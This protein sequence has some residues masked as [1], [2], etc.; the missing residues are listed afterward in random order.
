MVLD[1]RC[2]AI[3]QKSLRSNM[4]DRGS[5]TIPCSIGGLE[6][7]KTLANFGASINVMP[8]KFFQKLRLG[9][10]RPTQ[11]TLQLADQSIK[12]PRGIVKDVLLK[13]DKYIFPTNFVVLD[14]DKE[15]EVPLIL[16]R[17]FLRAS[18]AL[19][20]MDGGEMTLRIG[21]EEITYCL[22]EAM[23]HSLNFNDICY[24]LDIN[25]YMQELIHPSPLEGW[26]EEGGD[27]G[28]ETV[29]NK[30]KE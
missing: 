11:M 23:R 10:P 7:E 12:H 6:Q 16:G 28:I 3:V 8:H 13:V 1:A 9:E 29:D 4:K 20:D 25:D 5:F 21:D 15:V 17:S 26:P 22:T 24:S 14:M 2:S 18:K 19:I 27:N 30:P